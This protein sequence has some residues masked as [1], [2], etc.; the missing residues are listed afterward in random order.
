M[1]GYSAEMKPLQRHAYHCTLNLRQVNF[2]GKKLC[3]STT[4]LRDNE[5]QRGLDMQIFGSKLWRFFGGE[6]IEDGFRQ[7][8]DS[9]ISNRKLISELR[10]EILL[11]QRRVWALESHTIEESVAECEKKLA[12]FEASVIAWAPIAPDEPDAPDVAVEPDAPDVA[13]EP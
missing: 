12:S 4:E 8:S 10:T 2:T 5:K 6:R 13:V 1:F 7:L 9:I 11:L 3:N